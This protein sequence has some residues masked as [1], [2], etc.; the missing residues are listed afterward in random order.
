[1]KRTGKPKTALI[2]LLTL[3][4]V[5]S[6]GTSHAQTSGNTDFCYM[7]TAEGDYVPLNH[8]C[9]PPSPET[10]PATAA[11]Q[12]APPT[13]RR[14][15][16]STPAQSTS[17]PAQSAGSEDAPLDGD[18]TPA[19]DENPADEAPTVADPVADPTESAP[20]TDAP[21]GEVAAPSDESTDMPSSDN[22][23]SEATG[24]STDAAESSSSEESAE[25]GVENNAIETPTDGENTIIRIIEE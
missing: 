12:S 8:L 19:A 17:T 10:G 4:G 14:V 22:P 5:L 15:R 2:T 25:N 7:R 21:N 13:E 11:P 16:T 9:A 1:M 6:F 23:G 20:A 24:T 18:E 3:A